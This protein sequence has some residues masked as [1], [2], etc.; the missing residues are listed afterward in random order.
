[1]IALSVVILIA[2]VSIDQV[3][4]LVVVNNIVVG[5]TAFSLSLGDFDV[6]S[7]THVRNK[8][9]AWS[10][11][12]GKTVL[13][14]AIA[15]VAVLIVLYL[16][17]KKKIRSFIGVIS[18][19]AMI[20]GGIGN[21]LDRIRLN[22]VVDYIKVDFIDFPVFNFADICVVVGAICFCTWLIVDDIKARK[23]KGNGLK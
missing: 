18:L 13:L 23:Q 3:I 10:I 22:E 21:M 5:G 6:F 11:L 2:L 16:I 19:T 8:G 20:S 7:I 12:E 1:M 17:F 15:V 14:I 4:K 9:A